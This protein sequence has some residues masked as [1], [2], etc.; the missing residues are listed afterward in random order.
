MYVAFALQELRSDLSQRFAL[1]LPATLAFDYP[2][3]DAIATLITSL[4]PKHTGQAPA[5]T[6]AVGRV[7]D[8]IPGALVSQRAAAIKVGIAGMG[9]RFAGGVKEVPSF[10]TASMQSVELHT[11]VP[12][13][14]FDAERNL[15]RDY[16]SKVWVVDTN[17]CSCCK[18]TPACCMHGQW[19]L[20]CAHIGKLACGFCY[21]CL[22]VGPGQSLSKFGTYVPSTLLFDPA[23]FG[24][25]TTEA[26]LLEPQTRVLLMETL[27]AMASTGRYV[28]TQQQHA[29]A[30]S[31]LSQLCS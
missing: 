24:L 16:A 11:E 1:E 15:V 2:T 31:F 21:L 20:A 13:H 18:H 8:N 4:L 23:V 19:C 10:L 26:A 22:Q 17:A 28:C 27:A 3:P 12:F 30:L 25:S 6:Q 5:A 14:R 29:F 9:F 7:S